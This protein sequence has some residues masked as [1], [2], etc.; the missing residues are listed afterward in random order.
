MASTGL[1]GPFPLTR[2]GVD[3]AVTFAMPGTYA[4]GHINQHDQFV[5]EYAGRADDDVN[6]R[7]KDHVPEPYQK[8]KFE[9]YA[10]AKEAYFKECRIYHDFR[11]RDNKI[12]PAA[13]KGSYLSCPVCGQ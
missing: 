6:A 4:L 10:S 12:H 1:R 5:V 8:F 3:A 13:P 9:Y 2:D 11:P 7:L